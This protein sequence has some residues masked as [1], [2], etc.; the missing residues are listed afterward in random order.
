[1]LRFKLVYVVWLFAIVS[2][3]L[4]QERYHS[5]E[6]HFSFVAPVNW[7][8]VY[9]EVFDTTVELFYIDKSVNTRNVSIVTG[10]PYNVYIMTTSTKTSEAD[11]ETYILSQENEEKRQ[12]ALQKRIN[13]LL[14]GESGPRSW[15]GAKFIGTDVYYDQE[16]HA[17]FETIEMYKE[18][19]GETLLVS[20]DILGNSRYTI[21]KLYWD[22][23]DSDT[24]LDS[25]YEI[26]DSF[27][28]DEG[29]GLSLIH[30]SEPTRPY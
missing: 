13:R 30:I 25:V 9:Q 4:G 3:A 27:S 24:F 22:G 18:R 28:Y 10:S 15:R 12:K 19:V 21:F 17:L 20:V 16:K 23:Q 6:G 29:Y 7:E 11:R 26:V 14:K 2:V 8:K 1:M 5:E